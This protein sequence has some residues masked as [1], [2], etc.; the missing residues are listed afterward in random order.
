M[1][2]STII[3][4]FRAFPG[5]PDNPTQMLV[6]HLATDAALLPHGTQLALLDVAYQSVPAAI[7]AL[8][9]GQPAALVLTGYSHLATGVTLEACATPSCAADKPDVLGHVPAPLAGEVL[10]TKADLPKL[11][12]LLSR[13]NIPVTI[14]RDA[15][16]YLRNFS[17]RHALSRVAQ[18]G[19]GT[20]VLFVHLPALTGTSLAAQSAASMPL[21]DMA[22]ALS[23][24]VAALADSDY[25]PPV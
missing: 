19:I 15:G 7:D 11:G 20:R 23:L 12:A 25:S 4:G 16:Q 17:Y 21:A 6:E 10:A 22:R 3:T 1:T 5:V 14:S 2:P 18:L 13:A 24:I 8:L 9:A